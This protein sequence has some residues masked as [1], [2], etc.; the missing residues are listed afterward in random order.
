MRSV[1]IFAIIS[2]FALSCNKK[3]KYPNIPNLIFSNLSKDI[4]QAGSDTTIVISFRFEDGDGNIGFGT[5]NLFLRDN[6]DTVWQPYMIPSI[7]DKF[8]PESGLAG[9]ITVGYEAAFLL[10]RTDAAHTE[11][12]TLSWDIYLKDEAGNVSN[13]ITSTPLILTK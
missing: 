1:T 9:I 8:N 6:R 12:D 2:L 7:P 4:V 3:H 10:L 13:T 11:T 5:N